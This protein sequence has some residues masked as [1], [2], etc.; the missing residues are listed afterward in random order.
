MYIS[1]ILG[2]VFCLLGKRS[3]RLVVMSIQVGLLHSLV[4]VK[5]I[6]ALLYN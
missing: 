2:W 3:G 1:P 6:V 4:R 5:Q